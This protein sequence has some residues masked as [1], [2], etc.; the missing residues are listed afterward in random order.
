MKTKLKPYS[1]EE[2]NTIYKMFFVSETTKKER[3]AYAKSIGRTYTQISSKASY[4]KINKGHRK[5][6]NKEQQQP[7][8][9]SVTHLQKT[10]PVKPSIITI[11]EAVVEIPSKEFSVNGVKLMW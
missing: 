8:T 1:K 2:S 6:K 10:T 5:L 11:G 9:V 7:A 4:E 3:E